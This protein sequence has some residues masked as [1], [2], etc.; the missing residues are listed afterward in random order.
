MGC[1]GKA[2]GEAVGYMLFACK[3][4]PMDC[5]WVAGGEVVV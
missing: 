1:A 3:Q 5:F 2:V 4:G